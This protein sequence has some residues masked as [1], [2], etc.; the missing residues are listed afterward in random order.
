[1]EN[2]ASDHQSNECHKVLGTYADGAHKA[3]NSTIHIAACKSESF[4]AR[5]DFF[6]WHEGMEITCTSRGGVLPAGNPGFGAAHLFPTER[7]SGSAHGGQ[8]VKITCPSWRNSVAPSRMLIARN[9]YT[10]LGHESPYI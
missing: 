8:I 5:S 6:L 7:A 1:M 10:G 3:S 2:G 4:L 9:Y